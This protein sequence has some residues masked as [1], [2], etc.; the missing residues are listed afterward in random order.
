MHHF[1][2]TFAF[3]I[4]VTTKINEHVLPMPCST[5]IK[6][7]CKI[8]RHEGTMGVTRNALRIMVGKRVEKRYLV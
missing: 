3:E 4:H 2:E 5:E 6:M 7:V 8:Y 1:Y